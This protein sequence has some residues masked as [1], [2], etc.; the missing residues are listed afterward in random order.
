MEKQTGPYGSVD[1][2]RDYIAV[3][4]ACLMLRKDLFFDV[5]GFDED[6]LLVFSDVELCLRIWNLGY[7]NLYNPFVRLRHYEGQSRGNLIPVEDIQ[8][9]YEHL[10]DLVIEGDPYYNP[11]LSYGVPTPSIVKADEISRI[12]RLKQIVAFH[13]KDV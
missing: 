5:G 2:Y 9:G 7:R 12:E 1:W 6:Y 13:S 10:G 11:N 8:L 3:T 4:G